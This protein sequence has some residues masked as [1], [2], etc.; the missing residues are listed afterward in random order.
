M[1]PGTLSAAAPELS[2]NEMQARAERAVR[3]R[4]GG[5]IRDLHI[6]IREDDVILSGVAETYY[7]K[8]G[9][10]HAVLGELVGWTVTNDIDVV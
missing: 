10:T 5:R 6:E 3:G 7:A 1:N 8:Q 9:A 2:L 4:T